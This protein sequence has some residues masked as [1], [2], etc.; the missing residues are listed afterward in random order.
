MPTLTTPTAPTTRAATGAVPFALAGLLF[1]AYPV[2]RPW[3][4]QSPEGMPEAFASP[5]WLVSHLSAA[6]GFLLVGLGLLALRDRLA[7][8]TARAALVLWWTGAALTLTY[9][10]AET[11]ALNALSAQPGLPA[12]AEAV[13]MGPTQVA[14][15]GVGLVL[16]AVAGVLTA[17][18][19]R[20]GWTGVPFAL[21]MV[22]FLPQFFAGP[23]LRIAHGVLLGA[24]CLLVVLRGPE[25]TSST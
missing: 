3:A 11:F 6:A 4:D 12:L 2:L 24:G 21:G 18:A 20:P 8:A 9:Y 14:V 7:T 13:R 16:L 17:L 1:V 5:A 22:L 19:L 15:F 10:G 23:G 25:R